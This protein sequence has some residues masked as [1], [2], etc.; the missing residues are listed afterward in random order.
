MSEN[1]LAYDYNLLCLQ[2]MFLCSS[3]RHWYYNQLKH[4]F[5]QSKYSAEEGTVGIEVSSPT[6]GFLC[7]VLAGV[8][9][10]LE[11]WVKIGHE[12]FS[13]Y[14]FG[15]SHLRTHILKEGGID[16]IALTR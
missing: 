12:M 5:S 6:T 4:K 10:G 3:R 2:R 8:E 9:K 14:R 11:R 1:A 15:M 13:E 7:L 16:F